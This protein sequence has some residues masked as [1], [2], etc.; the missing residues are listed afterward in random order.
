MPF[1]PRKGVKVDYELQRM[2]DEI[3]ITI[4][5]VWIKG[6]LFLVGINKIHIEMK[7]EDVIAQVG[8]GYEKFEEYIKKNH[9]I[10]ER[11]V[12]I[13]MIQSKESLEWCVDAIIKG[14]KIPNKSSLA[15]DSSTVEQTM[16]K[17]RKS[18]YQGTTGRI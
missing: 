9:K 18:A 13:K 5:I 6:T 8:G 16:K 14:N 4:P 10:L 7:A 17:S 2:I 3:V 12:L 1:Q 11:A 15:Y